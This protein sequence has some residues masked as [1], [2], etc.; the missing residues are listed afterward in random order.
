M[1][2]EGQPSA[3]DWVDQ[4][5]WA[6]EQYTSVDTGDSAHDERMRSMYRGGSLMAFDELLF[7]LNRAQGAEAEIGNILWKVSRQLLRETEQYADELLAGDVNA[8]LSSNYQQA[9][10][11]LD[12]AR[13]LFNNVDF[14]D[15]V[16]TRDGFLARDLFAAVSEAHF[17][18]R[19]Y[20]DLSTVYEGFP[21]PDEGPVRTRMFYANVPAGHVKE[22]FDQLHA[23]LTTYLSEA[24]V[25]G[26]QGPGI[27]EV[28]SALVTL[29][30]LREWADKPI[31]NP[32]LIRAEWD[33]EDPEC[34]T[35][36]DTDSL[37]LQLGLMDLIAELF[38]AAD[39]G[40]YVRSA[41]SMLTLAVRFRVEAALTS[42]QD[43]C[44]YNSPLMVNA[45][46]Q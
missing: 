21:M 26:A 24:E 44:G 6:E 34:Q 29:E 7:R 14:K 37:Y 46:A 27:T 38:A 39:Q 19:G 36:D 43:E 20:S 4:G 12:A 45:R 23:E 1:N 28:Q 2:P 15:R 25:E 33:P 18:L 13:G 8:L 17:A 40:V 5:L 9:Q 11:Y 31:G 22:A 3:L 41:Q 10:L 30:Q 35:I 42:V 16:S 32:C